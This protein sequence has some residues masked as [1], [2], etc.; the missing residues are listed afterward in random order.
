MLVLELCNIYDYFGVMLVHSVLMTYPDR[1]PAGYPSRV[2]S[3]Q[4]TYSLR[5]G[6]VGLIGEV[7]RLYAEVSYSR[8]L[9]V[10]AYSGIR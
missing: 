6:Y 9:R 3:D 4:Q 10:Q 5:I 7:V 1:N 2:L 8:D